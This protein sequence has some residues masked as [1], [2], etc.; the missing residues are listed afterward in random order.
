MA[1][2][3]DHLAI[4]IWK[5]VNVQGISKEG[6]NTASANELQ[7]CIFQMT[8]SGD[9]L[10]SVPN[11]Q[12]V[13]Y[14]AATF[15]LYEVSGNKM[16][17]H[18]EWISSVKGYS[19]EF[20]AMLHKSKNMLILTFGDEFKLLCERMLAEVDVNDEP[21]TLL[22]ALRE[23]FFSDVTIV[24]SN[25][26]KFPAHLIILE[27]VCPQQNW[28]KKPGPLCGLSEDVTRVI[29][30]YVYSEC[31]PAGLE[32][33]TVKA[34]KAA[35][36]KMEG[37]DSLVNLCEI[38]I[39]NMAVK[40]DII[41]HVNEI[42]ECSQ[43]IIN[44]FQGRG[45]GGEGGSASSNP[46]SD[47]SKFCYVFK[48]GMREAM[49]GGVNFLLICDL[50]CR[51]QS[52]L[53]KEERQVIFT[54]TKSRLP[55]FI[56]QLKQFVQIL[57]EQFSHN[58]T[59]SQRQEVA[60]YLVPE[61]D[62]VL[63]NVTRFAIDVKQALDEVLKASYQQLP[64][65][66]K[67]DFLSRTV[68]KAIHAKELLKME[69]VQDRASEYFKTLKVRKPRY[70]GL[71]DDQKKHSIIKKMEQIIEEF[72]HA[73]Y[74]IEKLAM[75]IS[76]DLTMKTWKFMFKLGTSKVS[77]ALQQ[78]SMDKPSLKPILDHMCR[79]VKHK[80]F[81]AGLVKLGLLSEANRETED[82]VT[83]ACAGG[84]AA[85]TA[86]SPARSP[87][88][89]IEQSRILDALCSTPS[90][91][92]SNLAKCLGKLLKNPTNTDMRF[93]V[94]CIKEEPSDVVVEHSKGRSLER[95]GTELEEHT[96]LIPAHR[97]VIA[98]RCDWFRRAL[99]SG[100]KESID[101]KISVH[102]AEPELFCQFLGYL[103]T[104][105]LKTKP[106]SIH[107]LADM[108]SLCDRYEVDDLKTTCECALR[109]RIDEDSALFML[110]LADQFHAKHLREA[111][112]RYVMIHPSIM[113]SDV[114]EDLPDHLQDEVNSLVRWRTSDSLRESQLA[115]FDSDSDDSTSFNINIPQVHYSE[116]SYGESFESSSGSEDE[117]TEEL[118]SCI[119]KLRDICGPDIPRSALVG[120]VI[121][122]DYDVNR[123]ANHYFAQ[124]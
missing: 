23:G 77:W 104:G 79:L 99:L 12:D 43:R 122:A 93:E 64:K 5:V 123:A 17:H 83:E 42:H 49:L 111:T 89:S 100:M 117:P 108:L 3:G 119:E 15:D 76:S 94:I 14:L 114:F 110:S 55:G 87:L 124:N 105:Q 46:L 22:P 51:R 56:Q 11:G 33:E 47:P 118:N 41:S 84:A 50:F 13:P 63:K 9:L 19:V 74:K 68:K 37:F 107:Q 78:A 95:H 96:Q 45:I 81:T 48:Q 40:N 90:C 106:L 18:I 88:R 1:G 98:S 52:E 66:K 92:S 21:L 109:E 44:I 58:M 30:H 121:A 86:C 102:D 116:C 4:G 20:S 25:S 70:E 24:T 10:W 62:K 32:V 61:I 29:L 101:R 34:C 53:S 85:T 103:Y 57:Q 80:E 112:L 97:V 39:Q 72:P 71:E 91:S 59:P 75:K 28:R 60:L 36:S 115:A 65:P 38:F 26:K 82:S 27:A 8:D 120:L 67:G 6:A 7:G 31:L 2:F 69:S 54:Y 73:L 16:F 113:Q 35:V